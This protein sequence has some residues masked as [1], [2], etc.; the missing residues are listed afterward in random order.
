M[1]SRQAILPVALRINANLF[2]TDL[3][4]YPGYMDVSSTQ[5][6]L[7]FWIPAFPAGTTEED[8]FYEL[9]KDFC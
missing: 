5:A 8:M 6:I 4:R 3:R 2:H 7:G 9:S 1:D